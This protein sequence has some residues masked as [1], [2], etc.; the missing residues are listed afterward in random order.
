MAVLGEVDFRAEAQTVHLTGSLADGFANRHSDIDIIVVGG[1]PPNTLR[2][3]LAG[4]WIDTWYLSDLALEEILARLRVSSAYP[5][6]WGENVLSY[7]QTEQAHRLG[8]A[9]PFTPSA[10]ELVSPASVRRA[11]CFYHMFVARN[12]R[13]DLIGAIESS[14]WEQAMHIRCMMIDALIDGACALAGETNPNP[15]WRLGKEARCDLSDFYHL[16]DLKRH[17]A[18]HSEDDQRAV[19]AHLS[20]I[21]YELMSQTRGGAVPHV[22]SLPKLPTD[23]FYEIHGDRILVVGADGA[24]ELFAELGHA[25]HE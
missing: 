14:Q 7:E 11:T 18:S 16:R 24:A 13:V 23:R 5:H 1:K 3:W 25:P 6:R 19:A 21:L 20:E 17:H 4:H 8:I 15:K 12:L 10:S 2:S 22:N 9:L